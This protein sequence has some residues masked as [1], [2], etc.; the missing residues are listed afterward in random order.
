MDKPLVQLNKFFELAAERKLSGSDQLVYLH[1]FNAFN[2]AH[3]TE[4][5]RVMDRQL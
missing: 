4:T 5:L 1:L 3:W 2:R